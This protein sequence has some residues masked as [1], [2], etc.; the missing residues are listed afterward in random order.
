MIQMTYYS[1]IPIN[2]DCPPYSGLRGF[3]YSTGYNIVT[4]IN[5]SNNIHYS[6]LLIQSNFFNNINLML[7]F[8]LLV[9][10][11]YLI[12]KRIKLG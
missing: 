2:N 8:I 3:R 12:Y 1:L 10:I 11:L 7:S 4:S 5:S 6:A 9:P